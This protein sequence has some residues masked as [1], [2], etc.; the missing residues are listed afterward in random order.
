[1][2]KLIVL[3]IT[4]IIFIRPATALQIPTFKVII[5]PGMFH[6]ECFVMQP[7]EHLLYHFSSDLPL[8]FDLHYHIGEN[9]LYPVK[10]ENLQTLTRIFK[11]A[12][13]QEYCLLWQNTSTQ[14]ASLT[15]GFKDKYQ[16]AAVPAK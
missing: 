13:K 4:L 2:R 12:N 9:I 14:R 8:N 7:G 16:P 15:Y 6:E 3:A 10:L 5:L 11:A 1:M